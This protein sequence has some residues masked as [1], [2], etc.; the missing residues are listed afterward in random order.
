MFTARSFAECNVIVQFFFFLW[1]IIWCF[2]KVKPLLIS[3]LHPGLGGHGTFFIIKR[4]N[5]T[6]C[7]FYDYSNYST[8]FELFARRY[9]PVF[10]FSRL[11][12]IG[13][14]LGAKFLG[15]LKNCVNLIFQEVI[16]VAWHKWCEW[17]K[18][19]RYM[20]HVPS[21]YLLRDST[22]LAYINACIR[23]TWRMVTQIPPMQIE[24]KSL[25][26]QT[27]I[28]TKIGYHISPDMCTRENGSSVQS[29][30][31]EIACYLWP[32]LQDGGGRIIRAGEVLCK[33]IR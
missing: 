16:Q 8:L 21:T 32:G 12:V 5:A 9:S 28:H 1:C 22:I 29:Q 27:D 19:D 33:I 10:R 2:R 20:E 23:L 30:G 14:T 3:W 11:T 18:N 7:I 17:Q 13:T 15:H 31:E 6:G 24:Y 25:Y 4:L 26:F